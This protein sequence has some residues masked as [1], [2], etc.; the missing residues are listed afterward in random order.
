MVN[1][2]GKPIDKHIGWVYL[3]WAHSPAIVSLPV[4][5]SRTGFH[6]PGG[7]RICLARSVAVE[8]S[9]QT[10]SCIYIYIYVYIHAS[11]SFVHIYIHY[12]HIKSYEYIVQ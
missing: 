9:L 10:K 6:S 11:S 8:K 12:I 1:N 4:F 3:Y 2:K 5:R 7:G